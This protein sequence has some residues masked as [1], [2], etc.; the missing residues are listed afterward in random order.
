MKDLVLDA[1][2]ESV[3]RYPEVVQHLQG[4]AKWMAQVF[5]FKV[6]EAPDDDVRRKD[7]RRLTGK[8]A[9]Y[10][11]G[12][13]ARVIKQL[14]KDYK[15]FQP[16]FWEE[17]EREMWDDLSEYF[18]GI[19]IHGANGA[20]EQ[21]TSGHAVDKDKINLSIIHFARKYRNEWLS[22]ITESSR[23]YVE[24]AITNWQLSGDPLSELI[25]TLSNPE[26]GMF[27]KIRAERIAVTEVTRL[28]SMG[29]KLAWEEAGYIK[30]F[31]WHTAMDDL[32]CEICG[33]NDGK[34]FALQDMDALIPAHVN[35]RCWGTPIVD[36]ELVRQ[37]YDWSTSD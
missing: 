25:K 12:L 28:Y 10:L 19:I 31:T 18:T 22:K 3:K 37:G 17:E 8:I 33:P 32:V 1:L 34:Q 30:E 23:S 27:S 14:K 21:L 11:A 7:E 9:E 35:C 15:S 16:S 20:V 24:Q 13:L 26:T 4:D 2:R 36:T 6:G 29:N 5:S